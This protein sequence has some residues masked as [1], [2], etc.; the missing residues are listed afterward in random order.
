MTNALRSQRLVALFAGGW[1]LL[2]FPL[3]GL[4]DSEL[5]VGGIALFPLAL[6]GIWGSTIALLAIGLAGVAFTRKRRLSL[7]A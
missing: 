4:W 2:N 7:A 6:F 5:T 1:L 3:L